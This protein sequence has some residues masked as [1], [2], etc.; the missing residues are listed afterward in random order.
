MEHI[1]QSSQKHT[2]GTFDI[3]EDSTGFRPV[4]YQVAIFAF[5]FGDGNKEFVTVRHSS[6]RS[7]LKENA[8]QFSGV[9]CFGRRAAPGIVEL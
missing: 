2:S 3:A 5:P 8:S 6:N 1:W 7:N 4:V 9:T